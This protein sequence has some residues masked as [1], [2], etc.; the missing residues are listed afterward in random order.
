M[1]SILRTAGRGARPTDP[2]RDRAPGR[3][4]PPRPPAR[5]PARPTPT[6]PSPP[7]PAAHPQCTCQLPPQAERLLVVRPHLNT[8]RLV[9][10]H[11][12]GVGLHVALVHPGGGE[13]VC[14]EQV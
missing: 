5:R 12:A 3:G 4:A 9:D 11:H 14:K 10:G 1:R 2:A 7:P 8:A 6:P 13:G